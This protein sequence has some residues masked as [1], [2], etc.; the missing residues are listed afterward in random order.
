MLRGGSYPRK[1]RATAAD[2]A[3]TFAAK[4]EMLLRMWWGRV[5][6]WERGER[7]RRLGAREGDFVLASRACLSDRRIHRNCPTTIKTG[8][9]THERRRR[10]TRRWCKESQRHS[11]CCI[12]TK[13]YLPVWSLTRRSSP[14]GTIVTQGRLPRGVPHQLLDR[15]STCPYAHRSHMVLLLEKTSATCNQNTPSTRQRHLYM[16]VVTTLRLRAREVYLY[17]PLSSPK[18]ARHGDGGITTI[19][20]TWK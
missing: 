3:P 15:E 10:D 6:V 2:P 18:A 13:A 11:C 7:E 12:N 8:R 5:V 9:E 4:S 20:Q 19:H 16:L 14:S 17:S 1:K